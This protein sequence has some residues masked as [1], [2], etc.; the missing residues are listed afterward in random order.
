MGNFHYEDRITWDEL[1]PSLQAK[2]KVSMEVS[3]KLEY[4]VDNLVKLGDTSVTNNLMK[5]GGDTNITNNLVTLGDS[6]VT[7]NL[8]NIS[9]RAGDI[10]N[11]TNIF[12]GV[13]GTPGY[14]GGGASGSGGSGSGGAS[15][16]GG[17]GGLIGVLASGEKGEVLKADGSGGIMTDRIFKRVKM[18]GNS[19]DLATEKTFTS[20]TL[21]E[22]M[23]DWTRYTHAYGP[24][25]SALDKTN[26]PNVGEE[27]N[28]WD[29]SGH[30]VYLDKTQT[31][32]I[33]DTNT[34]MIQSTIDGYVVA[35]FISPTKSYD[36][37]KFKC[38]IDT[39]WDQDNNGIVV[40]YHKD[41]NGKEHTLT[42]MRGLGTWAGQTPTNNPAASS[43]DT[44]FWWGLIYDAGNDTQDFLID[45][46]S[47]VGSDYNSGSTNYCYITAQRNGATII[48]KTTKFSQNGSDTTDVPAWTFT[49]T[50]PAT[51]PAA[52]PQEE[53]DNLVAM[54][55]GKN[56]VGF[57]VR[58]SNQAK[59]SIV[60]QEGIYT[61]MHLYDLTTN[62]Y[63][64]FDTTTKT[65]V[66]KGDMGTEI[67]N[68][69]FLYSEG[70]NHF[71]WYEYKGNYTK[72]F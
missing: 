9:N 31:G 20:V 59:F 6:N 65:W 34:Q 13:P 10:I 57:C 14:T 53:Y 12:T 8:T 16:G 28:K 40:G 37:Y 44:K 70:T 43:I 27:Q 38:K 71:F 7:N 51:K 17:M 25:L 22:I 56:H 60:E 33:I 24:A 35:G 46:S 4:V 30:R 47:T 61:T 68:R 42:V 67:P 69:C 62:H 23:Q 63:W 15:S 45:L 36:N 48:G 32:W 29:I 54:L 11:T 5:I 2:F 19:T 3:S 21:Q 41:T 26:N 66:D 64:E 1:A 55:T 39:G 72:I 52:M 58:S 49:Y 18:A 50:L